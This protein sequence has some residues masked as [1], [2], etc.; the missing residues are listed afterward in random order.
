MFKTRK[1]ELSILVRE[2]RM[3][4]KCLREFP[5]EWFGIRDPE[6]RFRKRY[7]DFIFNEKAR[8]V[9]YLR[10]DI[11]KSIRNFLRFRGIYGGRNTNTITNIWWSNRKTF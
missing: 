9:I 7:L 8:R 2:F 5:K 10:R 1:G 3:L 4:A 11:I 6:L